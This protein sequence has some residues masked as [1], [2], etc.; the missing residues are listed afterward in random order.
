MHDFIDESVTNSRYGKS[1]LND[2]ILALEGMSSNKVRHLLNNLCSKPGTRYLEI[3]CFKGSTLVSALYGN[4]HWVEKAVAIDNFSEFGGPREE[5]HNN[6][7][8]H[9]ADANL[10]F[11]EGD[12]EQLVIPISGI[13]V[14]FYDGAHDAQSQQFA[15]H[16]MYPFLAKQFIYIVDDW[17]H[18]PA[19][20]GTEEGLKLYK[21]LKK[22]ELPAN[23]NGDKENYWNG[24]A[25]FL[26]EK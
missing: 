18:P 15:L 10:Q 25:I 24:I 9:I 12:F 11:I 20:E 26:L 5:L 7:K 8:N 3:G 22:V 19:R 2:E 17:N 4:N 13:N 14:Y 6:I 16:L 21:V 1:K 23:F